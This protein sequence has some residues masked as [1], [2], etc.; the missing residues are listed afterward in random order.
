MLNNNSN[1]NKPSWKNK[2]H[3]GRFALLASFAIMALFIILKDIS[4]LQGLLGF[5]FI[6]LAILIIPQK[7]DNALALNEEKPDIDKIR[8]Q[9]IFD[10]GNILSDPFIILD[11]KANIIFANDLAKNEFSELT[12]GNPISFYLRNPDLVLALDELMKSGQSQNIEMHQS[13]PNEKY[14][15]ISIALFK[16]PSSS[17]VKTMLILHDVSKQ[18]H[19]DSMRSDFIANASHELRT[20]LTSLIG[21]IETLQGSG[22]ND[23]AVREK[24]LKIMENQAGRMSKL[25]DDLLSLSRIE[26]SQHVKPSE[27][28][29]LNKTISNVLETLQNQAKAAGLKIILDM[30]KQPVIII[31]DEDELFEA[32]ENLIDNAIKY[33]EG[34][35]HIEIK[36]A[37]IN[38]NSDFDYR[39]NIIDF[40]QGIGAKHLPR[41]TERFYRVN[42]QNSKKK[43]GTGLGLAIV[44]H[45]LNR[46]GATMNITSKKDK[47]TNVEVLLKK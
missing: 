47:G 2:I 10:F 15:E 38:D 39:L 30:E 23:K 35:D 27:K 24:F 5:G 13:V 7:N 21:F 31:G 36:L 14:F 34:S 25:I 44:K 1:K 9:A 32:F 16:N 40:G 45:I 42:A 19:S 17:Q 29:D 41:L 43:K 26:Q 6:A 20:P 37:Q 22:A 46:H 11:E 12:I 3:Q 8:E 33:G 4:I 28:V 18:R